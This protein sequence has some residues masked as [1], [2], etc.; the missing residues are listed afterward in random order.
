MGV[1]LCDPILLLLLLLLLI[2]IIIIIIV[3]IRP[4]FIYIGLLLFF[5]AILVNV[6]CEVVLD[7][8]QFLSGSKLRILHFLYKCKRYFGNLGVSNGQVQM[9]SSQ[10]S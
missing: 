1:I 10:A 2:I 8:F 4:V 7:L 6:Y 3:I 9:R 5:G